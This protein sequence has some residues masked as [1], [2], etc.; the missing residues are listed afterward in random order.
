MQVGEVVNKIIEILQSGPG[1]EQINETL[2][3]YY[4]VLQV[5]RGN[6]FEDINPNL[7]IHAAGFNDND[8]CQLRGQLHKEFDEIRFSRVARVEKD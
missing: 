2:K 6:I 3:H 4:P 1:K 8:E 7:T 5:R